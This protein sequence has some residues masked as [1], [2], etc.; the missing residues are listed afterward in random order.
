VRRA[1]T[2]LSILRQ[3]SSQCPSVVSDPPGGEVNAAGLNLGNGSRSL[4]DLWDCDSENADIIRLVEE[5]MG[6]KVGIVE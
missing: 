3:W 2:Q 6:V 1:L 5:G 4:L